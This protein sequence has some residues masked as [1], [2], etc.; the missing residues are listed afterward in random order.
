MFELVAH[1]GEE[2]LY[3]TRFNVSGGD[4][5]VDAGSKDRLDRG[6]CRVRAGRALVVPPRS[7]SPV[8]LPR[9]G[10]APAIESTAGEVACPRHRRC[11][12]TLKRMK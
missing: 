5:F 6:E 7:P 9:G 8:A 10:S 4:E 11:D 12:A 2:T 3:F 1:Q